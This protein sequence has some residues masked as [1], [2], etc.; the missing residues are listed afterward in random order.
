M[1][2]NQPDINELKDAKYAPLSEN[3]IIDIVRFEKTLNQERNKEVYILAF[4]KE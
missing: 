1:H 3:E 4:E 2:T